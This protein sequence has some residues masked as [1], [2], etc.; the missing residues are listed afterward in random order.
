ME[1]ILY[2][3]YIYIYIF[4]SFCSLQDR[5]SAT[6]ADGQRVQEFI[7]SIPQTRPHIQ[8]DFSELGLPPPNLEDNWDN[9]SVTSVRTSTVPYSQVGLQQ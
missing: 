4:F 2:M 9:V 8:N 7:Q 5:V 3:T 6:G 1:N